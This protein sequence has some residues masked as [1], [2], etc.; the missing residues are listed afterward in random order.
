MTLIIISFI[1]GVLTVLAPCSLALLPIVIG[2]SAS[3]SKNKLKPFV[4]VG[5]LA[6]SIIVFTLLIRVSTLVINVPNSFWTLFS[7]GIL[8]VIGL[9][10]LFPLVWAKFTHKFGADQT[11]NKWLAKASYKGGFVG[12]ILTGFALG[13][14]F[15][16]CSP[17][18][19]IILAA[20]LPESLFNGIFLLLIYVL[21]LAALLLPIAILGQKFVGKLTFA[22]DPK[23]WFKKSIAILILIIGIAILTGVDK[24]IETALIDSGFNISNVEEGILDK[25][26]VDSTTQI[27]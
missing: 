20:V 4:I 19:F 1:A 21:G 26:K 10:M 27:Q 24:K 12:D 6:F 13:P 17:T 2:G 22:A 15:S 8:T 14:V 23:G 7:G 16:S 5:S 11:S 3:D 18:Y 9:I 25:F